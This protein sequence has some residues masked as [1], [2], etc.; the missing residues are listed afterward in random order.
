MQFFYMG[1]HVLVCEEYKIPFYLYISQGTYLALFRIRPLVREHSLHI[2]LAVVYPN[3]T[4]C[5]L[6]LVVKLSTKW[7]G[8]C[9]FVVEII[10]IK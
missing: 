10:R 3:E 1:P 8:Q 7:L 4:Y 5:V 9:I 6:I 2:K